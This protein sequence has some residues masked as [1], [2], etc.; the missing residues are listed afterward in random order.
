MM[1][2]KVCKDIFKYKESIFM[3]LNL[4]QTICSAGS[5]AIAVGLYCLTKNIIGKETASWLCIVGASPL[6]IAGFFSYNGLT[7]ERFIGAWFKTTLT[8]SKRRLYKGESAYYQEWRRI[9]NDKNIK[10]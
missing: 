5:I 8:H 6:A 9:K 4:R 3:G 2:I 7:V 1:E 10:K